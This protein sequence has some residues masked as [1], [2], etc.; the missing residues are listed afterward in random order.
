M[1]MALHIADPEVAD[2]MTRYAQ[3]KGL[4]KT[5]ALRRLLRTAIQDQAARKK[6][7]A[8]RSFASEMVRKAR[9]QKIAPVKK[10]EI[11]ALYEGMMDDRR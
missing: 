4:S 3:S 6:R 10:Q 11:D 8:F 7:E 1:Y 9:K 5:E 2:L